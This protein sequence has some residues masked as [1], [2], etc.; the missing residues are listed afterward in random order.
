MTT[1]YVIVGGGTAGCVVASR[2]S[3]IAGNRV[4]LVEAGKDFPDGAVPDDIMASYA[5]RA[6]YNPD[7]F[8]RGMKATRNA[9]TAPAYY[10]QAR[11][12]GGGSSINGQVALRGAPSDY[13]RWEEL[14][15]EGWNWQSVLPYFRK[16]E[17]DLDFIN[18]YHGAEGP[19]DIHRIPEER[20]DGF[21][22]AIVDRWKAEGFQRR[23]DMNGSFQDGF[24]PVPISHDRAGRVSTAIGYLSASVRR[25][26]NLTIMAETEVERLVMTGRQVSGVEVRGPAG[27]TTLNADHVVLCAG[28]LKSP[29]LMMRS[30]IGPADQL[31]NSQIK[32]IV[33]LPG[34]GANLQDHPTV[35]IVAYM[36][37]SSRRKVSRHN[38][39]N[40]VYSSGL[41][42]VPA[43]DMVM[44]AICKTA[45][46]ALGDRLGALSTY[47]GKPYSRGHL[48]IDPMHT[49]EPKVTFNWL[50]DERDVDRAATS[51]RMMAAML[52]SPQV[53]RSVLEIFAAGFSPKVKK[54][55]ALTAYNRLTT[56]F[57]GMMMD[58]SPFMRREIIR[59][60][61]S[62]GLSV[63]ELLADDTV[64]K[65]YLRK[66]TTGIWHPCGTCRMGR[67]DDP[68]AV[69]DP[70]G[71]VIGIENLSVAD[72]SIMPEIPTTNLNV[73]TIM[74]AEHISDILKRH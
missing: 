26:P 40:L 52:S 70:S 22:T 74:I 65:D 56:E 31:A 69:V 43:G 34:V 9:A 4:I 50:S 53:N 57:A 62:D 11:V 45:W 37:P 17:T 32:T 41:D 30:G 27:P 67:R 59:N 14:G 2:L 49:N 19:I 61:A 39:V 54:V 20:W 1:T 42:G 18:Q 28:S 25:R 47:V 6:L 7:Y 13:D 16:L 58:A 12:I 3:E 48:R 73:P 63:D 71:N 21:T 8:W 68:M 36:A 64:L 23:E 15:A 72:A 60:F 33:D 35:S 24:A 10:E 38:F 5:G 29:W 44:S 66:T 55:G 51:F 46:H